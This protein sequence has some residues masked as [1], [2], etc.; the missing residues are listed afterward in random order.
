MHN[1]DRTPLEETAIE[2]M[3]DDRKEQACGSDA[4]VP[5]PSDEESSTSA[6]STTSPSS[7]DTNREEESAIA[8][9]EEREEEREEQASDADE[10]QA[11][12]E[13]S[14]ELGGEDRTAPRVEDQQ[15]RPPPIVCEAQW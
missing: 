8:P 7:P 6:P 1:G 15:H 10:L 2:E 9:E 12:V 11:L 3:L 14:E 4:T 13:S 5:F